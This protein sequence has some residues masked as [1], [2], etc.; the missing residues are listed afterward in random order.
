MIGKPESSIA[1]KS[2]GL[3]SFS[4]TKKQPCRRVTKV[5][6]GIMTNDIDTN[7]T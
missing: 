7:P 2:F 4:E 5:D 6:L 1:R 3:K